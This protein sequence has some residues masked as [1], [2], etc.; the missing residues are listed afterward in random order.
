MTE[1]VQRLFA[2]GGAMIVALKRN[3]CVVVL[4]GALSLGLLFSTA[5]SGGCPEGTTLKAGRCELTSSLLSA[6]GSTSSSAGQAGGGGTSQPVDVGSNVPTSNAGTGAPNIIDA[7][8]SNA[9]AS[10]SG[11]SAPAMTA[12]DAVGGTT[13]APVATAGA[14]NSGGIGAVNKGEAGAAGSHASTSSACLKSGKSV[15]MI[16]DNFVN[17]GVSHSELNV[18]MSQIAVKDGSLTTGD[19]YRDYALPGTAMGDNTNQL[20][21]IP[22]QFDAAVKDSKTIQLVIMDGGLN[23]IVIDNMACLPAGS[24]ALA[25]CQTSVANALTNGMELLQHIK[26]SGVSDVIFFYYPHLPAG[27]DDII[28]YAASKVQT[29]CEN[30][31]TD[32]F[33]CYFLDTRPIFVGHTEYFA[34]DGI[35]PNDMGENRIAQAL[36]DIMKD[37]CLGQA[38][39]GGCCSP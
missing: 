15:V 5:C 30:I 14:A 1:V 8:G 17:Y 23:D 33:H 22:P 24:A 11:A 9:S 13:G 4:L 34:S 28:D 10:D 25:S 31:T 7:A 32:N 20:G 2:F 16:G 27:G 6:A 35:N 26:S 3:A 12:T 39:S 18:L 38:A 29:G 19:M 36:Y 37:H 21:L